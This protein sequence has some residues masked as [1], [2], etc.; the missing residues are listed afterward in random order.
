MEKIQ[1]FHQQQS[2]IDFEEERSF[3]KL[4][5][6]WEKG[7]AAEPLLQCQEHQDINREE[8]EK[9]VDNKTEDQEI[10]IYI[11]THHTLPNGQ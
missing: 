1:G 8:R 5:V 11:Y 10:Y 7:R 4:L 2:Y 9:L 6:L 3:N